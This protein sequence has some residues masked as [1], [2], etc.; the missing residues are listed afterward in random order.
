MSDYVWCSQSS[1]FKPTE[2][3][4]DD[5]KNN[6]NKRKKL[7]K[8][9]C[10]PIVAYFTEMPRT[11][12][13]ANTLTMDISLITGGEMLVEVAGMFEELNE[14]KHPFLSYPK[15]PIRSFNRTFTIIPDGSGCCIKN[16]Q[17]YITWPT[18]AQLKQLNVNQSNIQ[19]QK[20]VRQNR[21]YKC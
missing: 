16:E 7:Q 17:L 21:K 13:F 1:Q 19:I 5:R 18:E 15:E 9:G 12:H 6:T 11:T 3:F 8:Q 2:Y 14:R 4:M 20:Q 10:L